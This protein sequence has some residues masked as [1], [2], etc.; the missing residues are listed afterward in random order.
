[1]DNEY[2]HQEYCCQ[3]HK[4]EQSHK[5]VEGLN[6]YLAKLGVL[7]IKLHNIHWNVVGRRFF[8]IYQK[9]DEF[10]EFVGKELD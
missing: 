6:I 1:M 5:V 8:D 10:Y 7:Y 4:S 2:H 3:G 9:T